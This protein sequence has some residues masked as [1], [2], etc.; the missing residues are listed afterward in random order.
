MHNFKE[1]KVWRDSM[2]LA[3]SIFEITKSFPTD[4]KFGLTAQLRRCAVSIPSNIA[5]GSGRESKKEFCHFLDI[6]IG[7]SFELETQILL[8][9][10]IGYLP[11][12]R[13]DNLI[14]Q[15]IPVQKMLNG[16]KRSNQQV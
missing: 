11:L 3:K 10:E 7:S 13:L 12:D 6:S 9:Y 15:I 14:E 16:L 5:E 1:L 8:S 2:E 4:E